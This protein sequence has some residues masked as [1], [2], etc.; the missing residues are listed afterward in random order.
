MDYVDLLERLQN[1]DSEAFLEMTDRYGWS[2]YSAIK[3]KYPDA[4]VA[5]RIYQETM[6]GF[7]HSLAHSAGEDPVEA[8][9][10]GYA[11]LISREKLDF[12]QIVHQNQDLPPAI[13]PS[14]GFESLGAAKPAGGKKHGFFYALGNMG[15]LLVIAAVLWYIAALLMQ[16]DLIPYYD[17]G[18][19]W[20]YSNILE[21]FR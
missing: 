3:A 4:A 20:F 6:N 2:L 16:L 17:L 14:E 15:I 5:D 1:R 10:Q 21:I 7:Y 8:L 18:Y 19:S 11:G 13:T 12:H 9:L